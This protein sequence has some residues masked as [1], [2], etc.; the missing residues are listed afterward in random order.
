MLKRIAV[1][2]IAAAMLSAAP[3]A[4]QPPSP[5]A[6]KPEP[7]GQHVNVRIE[8]TITDQAGPGDPMRKTVTLVVADRGAGSIR[9]AGS[10]RDVIN[11]DAR[12]TVF[13]SNVVRL[14]LGLE[15]NPRV[16]A[17]GDQPAREFSSLSEQITVMLESGKPLVIS[18]AADPTSDRRI[19][20]EVR[21]TVS[22]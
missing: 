15:Y 18:Q 20:V 8:L 14:M 6:P 4:Q 10:P 11:V 12:P 19:A 22:K 9:N 1:I 3:A 21:A 2:A 17:T 13:G 5:P 7:S 16:S